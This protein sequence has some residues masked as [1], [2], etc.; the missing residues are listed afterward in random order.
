M[1]AL[2]RWSPAVVI[3]MVAISGCG[4]EDATGPRIAPC[5]DD[6]GAAEVT[7]VRIG[8]SVRF[9][10]EPECAVAF[11]L[12]EQEQEGS[13]RWFIK[14]DEDRWDDPTYPANRFAPPITYGVEPQGVHE[15]FGPEDLLSG[16][17]YVLVLWRVLP[18]NST[19]VCQFRF[20]TACLMAV[21][22]FVR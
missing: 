14:T 8:A 6:T 1:S 16:V 17:T 5:P 3:L 13:D 12:V 2:S 22:E 7:V 21:A 9:H 19:A 20:E 18:E 15:S 10:W 4:K 11:L